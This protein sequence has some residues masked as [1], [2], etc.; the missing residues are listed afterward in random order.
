[1]LQGIDDGSVRVAVRKINDFKFLLGGIVLTLIL[2][3]AGFSRVFPDFN[4][5]TWLYMSMQLFLLDPHPGLAAI[6]WVTGMMILVNTLTWSP[7][8]SSIKAPRTT[9]PNK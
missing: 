8:M 3:M 6:S 7:M 1:M 2:G 9:I 4:A 5:L